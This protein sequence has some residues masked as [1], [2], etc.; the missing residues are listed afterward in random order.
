M[1]E[2]RA[3]K[4]ALAADFL[5][6]IEVEGPDSGTL[7]L[8]WG[9]TFG[10]CRTATKACQENG[11]SVAHAHLRWINPFPGNLGEVLKRYDNVLIP[12]LNSG[13]L[14]LIIRNEFLVDAKGFNKVK[15]KPFS[16]TE[17]IE[18]IEAAC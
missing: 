1:V 16:V 3:K 9:G 12:E 17:L 8:S 11:K 18:A 14:R 4:V 5:D 10:A 15:G 7:V 2:T 6:P 13:Q